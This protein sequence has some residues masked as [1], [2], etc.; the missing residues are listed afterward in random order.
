M[1]HGPHDGKFHA[2]WNKLRDEHYSLSMKGYTGEGF[3]GQGR[4]LGGR[5]MPM[6]EMSQQAR[7][8]AA[9]KRKTF[10]KDAGGRRLG[11]VPVLSGANMRKVIADAAT[12]RTTITQGCASGTKESQRL[13]D[14]ASRNGF[15]TKAEEDDAND[16]AIAQALMELMEEE[17]GRR[18]DGG[19]HSSGGL[20][21]SPETGL[22]IEDD[23]DND[24]DTGGQ[25]SDLRPTEPPLQSNGESASGSRGKTAMV[26][27]R[28]GRPV[29]RL[30]REMEANATKTRRPA[31][32][33]V[34]EPPS[35]ATEGSPFTPTAPTSSPSGPARFS[36]RSQSPNLEAWKC[37]V[38]TLE[39]PMQYLCCDACGVE[40]PSSVGKGS[41]VL[42]E[43]S[44]S[45]I[46][47][48]AGQYSRQSGEAQPSGRSSS[49]GWTCRRCGKFMEK[50]W[51]TCSQC[52]TMKAS[53]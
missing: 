52:G 34:D 8:N 13:A 31:A 21:L 22:Y 39:N 27:D 37:P 23:D 3:L 33:L 18:L 19:G 51:W 28:D 10:N 14:Q 11:G 6:S 45:E 29:S 46:R 40:R 44:E 9:E 16:R 47:A 42:Q 12:R 36:P 17:E 20:G 35:E 30:V 48:N 5:R 38:C 41:N 49:I 24:N 53:S 7:A 32:T 26:R 4:K 15:Q 50:K 1:V 43:T 25:Q 2:L